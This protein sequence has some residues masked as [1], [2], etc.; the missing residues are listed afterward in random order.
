MNLTNASD[1]PQGRDLLLTKGA[2]N[3]L[4]AISNLYEEREIEFVIA[5]DGDLSNFIRR[6]INKNAN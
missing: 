2:L 1:F 6:F 5:G 4:Q 3:L